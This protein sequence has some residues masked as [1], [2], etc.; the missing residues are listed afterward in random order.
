MSIA[1]SYELDVV[2]TRG[3]AIESIHRVSAAVV[4]DDAIIGYA[5]NP[6]HEAYW[7]SCAKPFQLMP[8]IESNGLD[9]LGWGADEIALACASH[10]GEPEHV[11]IA[12]RM[13]TDLGLEEGDL[14]CGVAEPLSQRGQRLLRESGDRTTRLH[15]NCSGK[16]AAM[17]ARAQGA[18]WPTAGYDHLDH[19]VQQSIVQEIERWT[20]VPRSGM[21]IAR[22]GC[23]VPVFGLSLEAMARAFARFAAS[24]RAGDEI[25]RRVGDAMLANPFLVGG[26]DRFDTVLMEEVPGIVCKIGAEGVHSAAIVASGIGLAIKVEDGASR[27]QYPALLALLQH[28]GVVPASL[29]ERL[30]EHA[31]KPVRNTRHEIVGEIV[32]RAMM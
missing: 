3:P 25:P 6:E 8:F 29:P 26:T 31:R 2:V 24:I 12:E 19:P 4:K 27:A 1:T 17:L 22:D 32:V 15:N 21:K 11:A 28:L 30:A 23:G 9:E 20:G 5:R 16:H 10:G 13:L 18:Q 7:R 14:A